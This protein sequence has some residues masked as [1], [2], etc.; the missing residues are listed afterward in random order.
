MGLKCTCPSQILAFRDNLRAYRIPLKFG[1]LSPGA[2]LKKTEQ[3]H[4]YILDK[5]KGH[6]ILC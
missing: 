2:L 5:N 4:V 6:K 3:V 1:S